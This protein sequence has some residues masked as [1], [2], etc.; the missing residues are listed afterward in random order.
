MNV[1]E[2]TRL[3][4]KLLYYVGIVNTNI[5]IMACV[6]RGSAQIFFNRRAC[7]IDGAAFRWVI[8][9]KKVEYSEIYNNE[10]GE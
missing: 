5:N 1:W 8:A 3:N 4:H 9:T 7:L 10:E 6:W 2:Y